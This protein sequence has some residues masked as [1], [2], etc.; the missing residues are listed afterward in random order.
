MKKRIFWPVI[1][2]LGLYL[3]HAF[4]LEGLAGWLVVEDKL[5]PAD[6]I[7]VLSG[8]ADGERV[9]EAVRL[10]KRD[11]AKNI[12]MSGGPL[13]WH[14]TSAAWMKNQALSLGVPASAILLEDQSR[15]TKENALFSLPII[16][17][18]GITSIMLVTSPY[19]ARR[20]KWVFQKIFAKSDIKVLIYPVQNSAFQI[21]K[22]WTRHEDIQQ[23]AREYISLIFYFFIV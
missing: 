17:K 3:S 2:L 16:K 19:H 23:V 4:I 18:Q 12:L 15:S 9:A 10:Y 1:V 8:D 11:Y 22:W 5:E 7:L 20:A 6:I 13:A 21:S 14:L